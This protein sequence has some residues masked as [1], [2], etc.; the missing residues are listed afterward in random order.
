VAGKPERALFDE[1]LERIGARRPLMVG[2][3]F[4]T[5]I[6]G[7]VNAGIDSVAVLSGVDSLAG[8]VALEP[9]RRPTFVGHDV[10]CLLQAHPVVEVDDGSARCGDAQARVDE[11]ITLTSGDLGSLEGLRAVVALAWAWRDRSGSAPRLDG[12]MDS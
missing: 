10:S 8:L 1:T 7:A 3:R 9:D 11:S 6:D 4:D 5:D 12:T 2:D